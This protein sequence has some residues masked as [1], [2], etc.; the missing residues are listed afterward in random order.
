M[1]YILIL[2]LS[3]L[4]FIIASY[5][6]IKAVIF[7]GEY[8]EFP[9]TRELRKYQIDCVEYSL[10]NPTEKLKTFEEHMID[11]YIEYADSYVHLNDERSNNLYL[12]KLFY[13]I[14]LFLLFLPI[15][16]FLISNLTQ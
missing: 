15:I 5:K 6:L 10:Y 1:L 7:K 8:K 14:T 9:L 13:V 2:V 16:L 12:S 4:F 11:K 3:M